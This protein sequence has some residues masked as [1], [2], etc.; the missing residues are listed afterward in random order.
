MARQYIVIPKTFPV[1]FTEPGP[2][3]SPLKGEMNP[4]IKCTQGH[5][6]FLTQHEIQEDGTVDPSIVCPDDG[7]NWHIWGRLDGWDQGHRP[8]A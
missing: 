1:D 5:T 6:A 2:W 7:C 8:H 4:M 3:W